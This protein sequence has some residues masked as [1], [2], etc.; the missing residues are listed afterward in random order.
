MS[1]AAAGGGGAALTVGLALGGALLGRMMDR[2]GPRP[3]LLITVA[4]QVAFWFSVPFLPYG[5]LLAAAFFAG[6][7][8]VPAQSI[9]RQAIGAMT[10][11][12]HRRA[13]FALES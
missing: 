9:T 4:V 3:V 8:M 2:H 7:L 5:L 12:S 10:T 6:L 1:Y 11:A 13:A